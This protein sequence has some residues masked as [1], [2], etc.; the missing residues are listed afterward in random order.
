[1][2]AGVGDRAANHTPSS[3]AAIFFASVFALA[4]VL[5][6]GEL[7][8][9]L[10]L[11]TGEGAL[12]AAL[13][14]RTAPLSSVR[15]LYAFFVLLPAGLAFLAIGLPFFMRTLSAAISGRL[16]GRPR[17]ALLALAV[18]ALSAPIEAR[19]DGTGI[20]SVVAAGAIGIWQSYRLVGRFGETQGFALLAAAGLLIAGLV[21][22]E[23]A[24]LGNSEAS[25]AIAPTLL[26]AVAFFASAGLSATTAAAAA[27]RADGRIAVAVAWIG[28]AALFAAPMLRSRVAASAAGADRFELVC[29]LTA[30]A[31]LT[32]GGFVQ[33]LRA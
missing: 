18:C 13:L 11:H 33:R 23:V 10:L 16:R 3:D 14:A 20:M 29:T 6:I 31:L 2:S 7:L 1:L 28:V 19:F 21:A 24:A 12:G 15:P 22:Y 4:T 8:F 27:P 17:Q 25:I 26:V 9:R 30:A 32:G 5:V